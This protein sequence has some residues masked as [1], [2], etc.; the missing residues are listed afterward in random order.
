MMVSPVSFRAANATAFQDMI[1]RPQTYTQM[2]AASTNINKP[3]SK[4]GSAGKKVLGVL[5]AAGAIAA[6]L[7]AGHKTGLFAKEV[8]NE[9]IKKGLKGLN[10]AG[11]WLTK[12]G[13]ALI[14][15][16][17]GLKEKITSGLKDKADDTAQT[18]KDTATQGAEQIIDL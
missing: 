18:I 10:T 4:K 16:G 1:R 7:I 12:Q 15:K 8:K 2:P 11:E 17:K 3:E 5:I 9:Y 6:G 14:N 13:S